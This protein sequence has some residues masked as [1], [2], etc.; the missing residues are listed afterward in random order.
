MIINGHLKFHT[1]GAGELQNAFL[2]HDFAEPSE[3]LFGLVQ[4]MEQALKDLSASVDLTEIIAANTAA[5]TVLMSIE[6][7]QSSTTSL[8]AAQARSMG[9]EFQILF[10]LN[11]QFADP[12]QYQLVTD[13]EADFRVDFAPDQIDVI[14]TANPEV[15]SKFQRMQQGQVLMEQWDRLEK[16]GAN[17]P[18]IMR[19]YMDMIGVEEADLILPEPNEDTQA[20]MQRAAESQKAAAEAQ[21]KASESQQRLFD[22][23]S[24]ALVAQAKKSEAQA[25]VETSKLPLLLAELRAKIIKTLEEAESEDLKNQTSLYTSNFDE[26]DRVMDLLTKGQAI[27][28]LEQQQAA[29]QQQ[30]QQAAPQSTGA[31]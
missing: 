3:V 25:I 7:A 10:N 13:S 4:K 12:Q 30:P 22:A 8:I 1:Q 31:P 28:L 20:L 26:L 9:K 16:V 24:E 14:P 19:T 17:M 23:Q 11:R 5:T 18:V 29:P 27:Q 15:A 21:Q 6:Q 2:S